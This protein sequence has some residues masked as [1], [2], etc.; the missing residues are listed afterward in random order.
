MIQKMKFLWVNYLY[1]NDYVNC[2]N[3][4]YKLWS[5][6]Y[7]LAKINECIYLCVSLP[8]Q[9]LDVHIFNMLRVTF[10]KYLGSCIFCSNQLDLKLFD[11]KFRVPYVRLIKHFLIE[12]LIFKLIFQLIRFYYYYLN[13]IS[14]HYYNK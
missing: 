3:M 5:R 9:I 14:K 12:Q 10:I 6:F 4:C 1:Y 13:I 2:N 7:V 11:N 8:L